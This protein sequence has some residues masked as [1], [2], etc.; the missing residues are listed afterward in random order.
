MK[1]KEY[2]HTAYTREIV[3]AGLIMPT[4][5]FKHYWTLCVLNPIFNEMGFFVKKC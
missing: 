5:V 3:S 1:H 4:K 2:M